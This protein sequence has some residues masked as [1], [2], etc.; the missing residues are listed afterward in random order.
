MHTFGK[1]K[2]LRARKIRKK[3]EKIWNHARFPKLISMKQSGPFKFLVTYNFIVRQKLHSRQRSIGGW[4]VLRNVLWLDQSNH[5][6]IQ[7]RTL[8]PR[9]N[10]Y[11]HNIVLPAIVQSTT[12][13]EASFRSYLKEITL[14]FQMDLTQKVLFTVLVYGITPER[15]FLGDNVW[16]IWAKS[17]DSRKAY[18]YLHFLIFY[19]LF[20]CQ[21][22]MYFR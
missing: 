7:K 15:F 2:Q 20:L 6:D 4:P 17:F 8:I 1:K 13:D 19:L 3:A 5:L 9:N 21:L 10:K 12:Y 16:G 11:V 22:C 14:S 18:F